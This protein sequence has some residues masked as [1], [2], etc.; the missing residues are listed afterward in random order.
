MGRIADARAAVL[1]WSRTVLTA[2]GR[3]I[4]GP[5]GAGA[6]GAEFIDSGV[7]FTPKHVSETECYTTPC[8]IRIEP[9]CV[10]RSHETSW[11]GS[12]QPASAPTLMSVP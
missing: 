5:D 1:D 9:N 7:V 3:A 8:I 12:S 10:S 11:Q 4:E 6:R 2:R